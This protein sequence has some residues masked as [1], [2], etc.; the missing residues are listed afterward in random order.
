MVFIPLILQLRAKFSNF[1]VPINLWDLLYPGGPVAVNE[2]EAVLP[3]EDSLDLF[4]RTG[5]VG[6]FLVALPY[7]ALHI[8][9]FWCS[10]R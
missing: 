7:L 4:P 2:H 1:P 3:T 10:S 8:L 5:A 6:R 9:T